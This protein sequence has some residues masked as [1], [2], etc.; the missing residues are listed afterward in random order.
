M[1]DAL[2]HG[3]N[4]RG[5]H[6]SKIEQVGVPKKFIGYHGTAQTFDEFKP[7]TPH[8]KAT[9]NY[10]HPGVYFSGDP[11]TAASYASM[12]QRRSGGGRQQVIAAEIE[13]HN[14]LD[15][16]DT[17]KKLRKKGLSFGDAKREALKGVGPGHDGVVFRGNSLNHPEYIA[18]SNHQIKRIK[19]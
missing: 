9:G 3:S 7:N 12:D 5:A 15:I 1:K 19:R 11:Q 2:G 14:P 6:S 8:I 17:I 4:P 16:T 13:M 18:F 10:D